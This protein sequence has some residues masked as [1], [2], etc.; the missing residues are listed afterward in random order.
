MLGK[1][2]YTYRAQDCFNKVGPLPVCTKQEGVGALK[3]LFP[4][5]DVATT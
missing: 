2:N 5:C 3:I 1:V 4:H